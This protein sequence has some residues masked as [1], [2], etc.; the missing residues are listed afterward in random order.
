MTE[1]ASQEV[2]AEPVA[3]APEAPRLTFAERVD[4]ALAAQ[5]ESQSTEAPAEQSQGE[6]VAAE[7]AGEVEPELDPIDAL[8]ADIGPAEEAAASDESEL[9]PDPAWKG[10]S[11]ERFQ[12]LA[13]RATTAEQTAQQWQQYAL[14][15]QQQI[16]ALQ[17]QIQQVQQRPAQTQADAEDDDPVAQLERRMLQG[18]TPE[19]Q[20]LLQ[21][22]VGPLQQEVQAYKAEKA[23]LE[24]EQQKAAFEQRILAEVEQRRAHLLPGV[25][26][27][28]FDAAE[29][30]AVDNLLLISA[31]ALQSDD[32]GQVVPFARKN[33]QAIAKLVTKAA[34]KRGEGLKAKV[35]NA[36]QVIPMQ[37]VTSAKQKTHPHYSREQVR[38]AGYRDRFEA[39]KDGFAKLKNTQPANGYR[40]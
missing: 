23:R 27:S 15:M 31:L 13:N 35:A 10:K 18:L 38:A 3:D 14:G 32:L 12:K 16:Q 40:Y 25:D 33:M 28:E 30:E 8:F 39:H 4:Q 29:K 17:A 37:G 9:Q 20:K 26:V 36:G 24:K 19:F 21:E 34:R 11:Q 1:A 7:A 22:T 2:V 5:E 6:E